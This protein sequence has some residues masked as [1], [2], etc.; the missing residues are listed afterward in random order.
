MELRLF[1]TL[2]GHEG[3]TRDALTCAND[4]GFDGIEGPAPEDVTE[5]I[6]DGA[7]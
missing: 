2:W 6:I 7:C 5:A 1:K 4:N 3:S